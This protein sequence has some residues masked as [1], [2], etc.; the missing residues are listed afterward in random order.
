MPIHNVGPYL[1]WKET[2]WAQQAPL[3]L[4]SLGLLP[5]YLRIPSTRFFVLRKCAA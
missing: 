5:G 2:S 1:S 3:G 4:G